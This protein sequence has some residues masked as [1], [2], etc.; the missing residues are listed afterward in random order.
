MKRIVVIDLDNCMFDT[1]GTEGPSGQLYHEVKAV[2]EEMADKHMLV[3]LT[4]LEGKDPVE[5]RKRQWKKILP[6]NIVHHFQMVMI[7]PEAQKKFTMMEALKRIPDILS[8][9]LA[10]TTVVVGDRL[11]VE[12]M[13]ANHL[14]YISVHVRRGKYKN[15]EPSSGSEKPMY[16]IKDL[17]DLPQICDGE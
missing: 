17:R 6:C 2:I 16:T 9:S 10:A 13:H 15:V 12:I 3:L 11:D 14:G 7:V 5:E 4:A 1:H 8:S